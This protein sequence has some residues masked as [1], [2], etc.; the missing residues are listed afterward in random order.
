MF[1]QQLKE[2]LVSESEALTK[3]ASWYHSNKAEI[4]RVAQGLSKINVQNATVVGL[5][6]DLSI[7]GDKHTLNAIFAAFRKLGYEPTDRPGDKPSASFSC[8]WEHPT[9]D[10]RFWLY[11]SSTQ[12]TR[13][14]TGTKMV[15]QVVYETVCE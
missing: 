13:I 2:R 4:G 8:H 11:F 15:E 7:A 5:C 6:V 10:A 12:C 3:Q 1:L 9:E 14:K